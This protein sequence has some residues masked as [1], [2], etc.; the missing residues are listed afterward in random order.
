M[1]TY[2]T[3]DL[4]DTDVDALVNTV[5]TV[6]VMGKGLAL[7][8]K[9]RFPD[10]FRQYADACQR[11]EVELGRMFVVSVIE[12]STPR[13]II[14]FPTKSH[15]RSR[16][17][18]DAIEAGLEDLKRVV[19]AL[20]L[21][22]I[23]VPAL[24]AGNGGLKWADV[25]QVIENHLRPLSDVDVQVF[26]PAQVHRP[27]LP[28]VV[29]MTWAAS[30]VV[31]LIRAYGLRKIDMDPDQ[32]RIS[33]SHLEIQKL[34][35]FANLAVPALELDF[36]RG[37][38]GPYS[39][40]V[41]RLIQDMEGSF[42]EGF[43]DGTRAVQELAPIAPTPAGVA[44]SSQFIKD[45]GKDTRHHLV[46]PTLRLV[47]GFEGPYELEL[48]AST[49]W[50]ATHGGAHNP[51]EAARFIRSWTP[52]KARLF[53]DYHIECAWKHLEQKQLVSVA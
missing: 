34:L 4:F 49:H 53:T 9:R 42:V 35:Y 12:L 7:Q 33:A 8:F 15:W 16:S 1:I 47:E 38:Y 25:K 43:G 29:G 52:R 3:G 13:Y 22:S 31:E 39:D 23:A 24:G 32:P 14:N 37:N 18:L 36:S 51:Q 30:C 27:L 6:G 41:R 20:G 26:P 17:H 2:H 5:N 19:N 10:N 46:E 44:A 21:T 45:T 50:A 40:A 11:G 48:L 28:G